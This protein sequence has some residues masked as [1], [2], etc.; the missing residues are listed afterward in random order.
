MGEFVLRKLSIL[1]V[2]FLAILGACSPKAE[3]KIQVTN[4]ETGEKTE[5]AV[6]KSLMGDKETT[7]TNKENGAT[8]TVKE[9]SLPAEFPSYITLYQGA[10]NVATLQANDGKGTDNKVVMV[11]FTTNDDA[12]K[13]IE[14]YSKQLAA[15]G[16]TAKGTANMGSMAMTSLIN[17]KTEEALQIVASKADNK[18]ETAVQLIFAK[19]PKK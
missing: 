16:Y 15:N 6:S 5:V 4:P 8:L 7:I 9:G 10:K 18:D 19:Q 12:N 13:V 11:N 17:E 2:A 14:F 1:S 3:K